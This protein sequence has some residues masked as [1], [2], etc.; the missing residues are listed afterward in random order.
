MSTSKSTESSKVQTP[1]D[2][3]GPPIP[4]WISYVDLGSASSQ[5]LERLDALI[6]NRRLPG[7]LKVY[8]ECDDPSKSPHAHLPEEERKKKDKEDLNA[9]EAKRRQYKDFMKRVE[10]KCRESV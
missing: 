8:L 5:A 9:M 1:P 4:G 7:V 2:D 3:E 10:K 6:F